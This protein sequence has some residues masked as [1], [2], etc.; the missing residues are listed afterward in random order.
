MLG[1]NLR[2]PL[3]YSNAIKGSKEGQSCEGFPVMDVHHFTT[4]SCKLTIVVPGQA[5]FFKRLVCS[6]SWDYHCLLELAEG[7]RGK[8]FS[9]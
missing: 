6:F 3:L 1:R 7:T 4:Y 8:S 9:G 2:Q 5:S